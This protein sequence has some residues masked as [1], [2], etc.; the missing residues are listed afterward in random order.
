MKEWRAD[1]PVT[2]GEITVIPLEEVSIYHVQ[3]K[4]G[5]SI[6]ASKE[7]IGVAVG[8]PRGKWAIDI[9]G[10]QAPLDS[11]IRGIPG[12]KEMLDNCVDSS[13]IHSG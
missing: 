11:Y 4:K 1:T 10:E 12:L 5:L 6:Y 9:H 2:V 3:N 8:S 13:D 7:P